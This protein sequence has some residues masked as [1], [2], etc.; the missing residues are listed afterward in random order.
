ML[1]LKVYLYVGLGGAVGSLLRYGVALAS[2]PLFATGFP[3]GTILVNLIGAFILGWLTSKVIHPHI[4]AAIGTGLIGAFTTLS[5]LSVDA[6]TLI[7]SG[8]FLIAAF[9]I[10]ISLFGGLLFAA[11][12][13]RKGEQKEVGEE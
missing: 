10:F 1:E 3:V 6:V 13:L 12:G 7:D 8:K 2:K 5:T 4:R 11:F 9:Y